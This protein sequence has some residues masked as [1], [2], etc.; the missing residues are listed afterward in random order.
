M[1]FVVYRAKKYKICM[2]SGKVNVV[3]CKQHSQNAKQ[4]LYTLV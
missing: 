2:T 3:F 4:D 1:K